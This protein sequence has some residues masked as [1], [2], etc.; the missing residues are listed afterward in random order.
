MY[1]DL[2]TSQ[3]KAAKP[4]FKLHTGFYQ[5]Y[6]KGGLLTGN[7]LR[8]GADTVTVKTMTIGIIE[9]KTLDF[10]NSDFRKL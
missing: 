4:D 2:M 5:F 1:H 3:N 7:V 6:H 9:I 10:L 8:I